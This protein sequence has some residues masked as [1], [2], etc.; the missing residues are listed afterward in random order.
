MHKIGIDIGNTKTVIYSSKQNGEVVTDE[1]D[2]REIKTVLEVSTPKRNYGKGCASDSNEMINLRHRG[3]FSQLLNPESREITFMFLEYLHR[4]L[5]SKGGYRGVLLTIPEYFGF[6]EKNILHALLTASHLNVIGFITHLTGVGTFG[7]LMSKNIPE[8]FMIMDFGSHKSAIGIFT[9]KNKLIIPE[10]RFVCKRGACDFDEII[11][12]MAIEKY[13]LGESKIIKERIFLQTDKIK[14]AFNNL[15]SISFNILDENYKEINIVLERDTFIERAQPILEEIDYFIKTVLKETG[16]EGHIEIVGKNYQN[17]FIRDLLNFKHFSTLHSSESAAYGACLFFAVN[18]NNDTGYVV[19]EIIGKQITISSESGE[20]ELFQ[21]NDFI[22][23]SGKEG[24]KIIMDIRSTYELKEDGVL[25][26]KVVLEPIETEETQCIFEVEFDSFCLFKINKITLHDNKNQEIKFTYETFSLSTEEIENCIKKENE[27]YAQEEN[28][29]KA[30]EIRNMTE[31]TFDSL[32]GLLEE[33]TNSLFNKEELD[34]VNDIIDEYFSLNITRNYDIEKQNSD[35][36]FLKLEFVEKKL[37]ELEKTVKN[38]L[39]ELVKTIQDMIN[40]EKNKK[41][42]ALSHLK[43]LE[44]DL[45]HRLNHFELKINSLSDY[46]NEWK[47]K[48]TIQLKDIEARLDAEKIQIEEMKKKEAEEKAKKEEA[49]K[50]GKNSD[51]K[52][53]TEKDD[54]QE[55]EMKKKDDNSESKKTKTEVNETENH[56]KDNKNK[57]ENEKSI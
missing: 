31:K 38:E 26:G 51:N 22:N 13:G 34:K 18:T 19:K 56:D 1:F 53:D 23:V 27:F 30:G 7:G 5:I 52:D 8:R 45:K 46:D 55:D 35:E 16:F 36:Y 20:F 50:K 42:L 21:K 40:K 44:T 11:Y 15:S 41:L 39:E 49:A 6:Q 29:R 28:Y 2:A 24:K 37:G 4:I 48:V 10:N 12:R 9:K 25:F 57:C 47:E 33:K 43:V 32:V 54:N 3:F 14:K 17:K